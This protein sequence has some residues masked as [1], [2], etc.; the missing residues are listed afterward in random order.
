MAILF[1]VVAR[2]NIVL[3]RHADCVGNFAEVTEQLLSKIESVENVRKTYSHGRYLYHYVCYN[4]LIFMCIADDDF[5]RSV[6]FSFLD[7]IKRKFETQFG[8][9]SYSAIP[10]AM[11]TE[12]APVLASE[13]KRANLMVDKESEIQVCSDEDAPSTSS[14]VR[15]RKM[16]ENVDKVERV[17][18][19][20]AK[21][22]DIMVSNIDALIERG[23]RLDLLVEK[24]EDL[25]NHSVRFKQT[26][27]NLARKMWW[28]NTRAAIGVALTVIVVI[29]IIVSVSCGGMSWPECVHRNGT[30]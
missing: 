20:V 24:T 27:R 8:S 29:Y 9:Q 12:F 28:Q 19:E 16:P 6:A 30:H 4:G 14:S 21:V 26:S 15:G 11:N 25:S 17:R 23:E 2:R 1:S 10:F 3:A 22:K 18:D 5:R 7:K 13:M